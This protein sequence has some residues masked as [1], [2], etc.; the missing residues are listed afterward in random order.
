MENM[1]ESKVE[2]SNDMENMEE[3]FFSPCLLIFQD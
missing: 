2:L 3:M 1:E